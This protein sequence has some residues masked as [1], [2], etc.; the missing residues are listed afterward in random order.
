MKKLIT[1]LTFAAATFVSVS[2]ASAQSTWT[3]A[4]TNW[5]SNANPGWNGTGVPNTINATANIAAASG[6]IT[7]NGAFTLGTLTAGGTYAGRTLASSSGNLT[8]DVTTGNALFDLTNGGVV[9]TGITVASALTLNDTTEIR[10]IVSTGSQT[11]TF[12]GVISGAAGLSLTNTA[13]TPINGARYDLQ[14]GANSFAGG[15]SL[16]LGATLRLNASGAAGTG[17]IILVNSP[18]AAL[19]AIEFRRDT[20]NSTQ[21][22]ANNIN[23]G[24]RVS[25]GNE[26]LLFQGGTPS[27]NVTLNGVLS[28]TMGGNSRVGLNGAT[29]NLG[30]ASPNIW[31]G[32]FRADTNGTIIADKVSALNIGWDMRSQVTDSST[33]FLAGVSDTIAGNFTLSG[34]NSGV[35]F[36]YL[37]RLGLKDGN[38]GL[39]TLNG[40]ISLNNALGIGGGTAALPTPTTSLNLHS[41]NGTG[42]LAVGGLISDQNLANARSIS[43]TGTSTV[44][45]TRAAGNS[46]NGTTTVSG[47]TLLVNNLTGS[48]T[49]VG[50]VTVSTGGT[51]GGSGFLTGPVVVNTGATLS[52]GNSPGNLTVANDVTLNTGSNF[53]LELNG[54]T[55]ALYDRVTM[56]GAG[57]DLFLN[58][59]NNLNIF[60]GYSVAVNDIFFVGVGS[61]AA[62]TGVFEQLNGVNT[63]LTQGSAFNF[64]VNTFEISYTGNLGTTAFAGAGNDLVLRV[65]AIP[66]P[67]TYALI[68]SGLVA[69]AF[70]RRRKKSV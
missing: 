67:S 37:G 3:G 44:N 40:A 28:G 9:G 11:A 53:T 56:T 15:I 63:T 14:N 12:T 42:T 10:N 61:S 60:L 16:G 4:G 65:A 55:A 41:G 24:T 35:A 21:V 68:A 50:T 18:A 64:G 48:G 36:A 29:L 1:V 8:F 54:N 59:T 6:N 23:F 20:S 31:T 49:G 47:G 69:L 57:S 34:N 51:L 38:N 62:I 70:L 39:V 5:S 33:T 58:G 19:N 25:G 32:Q 13:G 66:E 2:T 52:P 43:I 7:V 17:A 46:Y 30:G 22:H 26:V 45:L 27:M